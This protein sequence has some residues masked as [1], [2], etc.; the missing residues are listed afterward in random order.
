V[1]IPGATTQA[2]TPPQNGNYSVVIT[3]VNGCTAS[4][5]AYPFFP[6][7]MENI[8]GENEVFIYPNPVTDE[9][10]VQSLK[11]KV[12]S[13]EV[14]DVV[15]KVLQSQETRTR[16]QVNVNVSSLAPGIYFVKVESERGIVVRKFVK[17]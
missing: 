5:T 7:S 10:T 11:F 4:S 9:L 6:T 15:G 1:I 17:I 2:Y 8:S 16:N 3:D 14:Y 12:E 13:V